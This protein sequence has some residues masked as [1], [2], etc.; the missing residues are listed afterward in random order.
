MV[1]PVFIMM[2]LLSGKGQKISSPF[3]LSDSLN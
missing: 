2:H 3:T 1:R